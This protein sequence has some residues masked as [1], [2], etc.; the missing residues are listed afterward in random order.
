MLESRELGVRGIQ[1]QT[2]R[3]YLAFGQQTS[4]Y[5]GIRLSQKA[6]PGHSS[7][8]FA[9]MIGKWLVPEVDVLERGV[10]AMD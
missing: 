4:R 7:W 1:T 10:K 2:L 9:S 3:A 8:F 6:F 5:C